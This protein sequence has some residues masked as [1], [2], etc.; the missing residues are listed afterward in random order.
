MRVR[1][2]VVGRTAVSMECRPFILFDWR[3]LRP[4]V[5]ECMTMSKRVV[6][7]IPELC[8]SRRCLERTGLGVLAIG[9][10]EEAAATLQEFL[11]GCLP[12][13]VIN[14]AECDRFTATRQAAAFASLFERVL[15]LK[16]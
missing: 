5:V 10:A 12:L 1:V 4:K 3:C 7:L 15:E 2:D 16:R 14:E 6:A 8:E 13:P 11:L 9:N